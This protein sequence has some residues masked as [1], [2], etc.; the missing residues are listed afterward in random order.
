MNTA[1]HTSYQKYWT[2][3]TPRQSQF[4]LS[5]FLSFLHQPNAAAEVKAAFSTVAPAS[6]ADGSSRLYPL[7]LTS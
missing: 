7:L 3:P 2:H 6:Q 1:Q 5:F 4:F